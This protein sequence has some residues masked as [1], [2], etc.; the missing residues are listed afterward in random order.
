MGSHPVIV[1]NEG[2]K[3][4]SLTRSESHVGDVAVDK[5]VARNVIY[6]MPIYKH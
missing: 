3:K 5:N 4:D 1:K 6:W 2:T